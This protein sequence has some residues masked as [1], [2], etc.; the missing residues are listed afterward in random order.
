MSRNPAEAME[1]VASW[2]S[3]RLNFKAETGNLSEQSPWL[4]LDEAL[5]G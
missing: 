3:G 1:R 2:N 5:T 4:V